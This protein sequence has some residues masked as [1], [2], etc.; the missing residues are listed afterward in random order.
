MFGQRL[1][2]AV[3][4]FHALGHVLDDVLHHLVRG[5]FAERL[6]R[7]H[8]RQAGVNHGGELAGED[9][10]VGEGHGAAGGLALAGHFFLDGNDE[11]VAVEQRGHGGLFVRGVHGTADF[12]ARTGLARNVSK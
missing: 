1:G 6:E 8:H 12:A 4:A 5:L 3:A 11:Q 10:E 9:D 2:E 7:L